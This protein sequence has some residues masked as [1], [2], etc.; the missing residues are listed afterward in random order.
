M[1]VSPFVFVTVFSV[2]ARGSF[3]I[4]C[5]PHTSV[6]KAQC[7]AAISQIIYNKDG[8]LSTDSKK[9]GYISGNCSVCPMS[10][11]CLKNYSTVF[12]IVLNPKGASLNKAQ[13]ERGFE[14]ILDKCK[15][16]TGGADLPV[17]EG[18]FLNIGNRGTAANEPYQSDFPLLKE[19][20]GLS[21][22]A[23]KTVKGDCLKAYASIPL[24]REGQFLSDQHQAASS[25]KKT[26]KTC[27][28]LF[29]TSDGSTIVATDSN[30]RPVFDKLLNTCHGQVSISL[31]CQI[32]F[33]LVWCG[34]RAKGCQGCQW[35]VV[36]EEQKQRTLWAR[37]SCQ[38]SLCLN[39]F[40]FLFA[41]IIH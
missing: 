8:T 27:T 4:D 11:S 9:L 15:P 12:I 41:N 18:V 29:S 28:I 1:L 40:K 25:V 14:Q 16:G 20:C 21:K 36:F 34:Q 6:D 32:L 39:C 37:R 3:A 5:Y 38:T 33:T 26:Y 17:G 24:S 19:T 13:I 31:S 2:L 22:G 23:P 35:Q 10:L 30:V 7:H